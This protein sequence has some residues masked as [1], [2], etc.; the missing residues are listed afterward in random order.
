MNKKNIFLLI[1]GFSMGVILALIDLSPKD[2]LFWLMAVC[3]S[4]GILLE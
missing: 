2:P 4:T 3:S 1:S